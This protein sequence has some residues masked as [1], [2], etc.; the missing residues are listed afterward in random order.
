MNYYTC[1][2]LRLEEGGENSETVAAVIEK[3]REIDIIDYAL[4]EDLSTSAPATWYDYDEDM[5]EVSRAFPRVHFVLSGD[6]DDNE[7]IWE[8]HFW[9][10]KSAKYKAEIR[11]P[12]LNMADLS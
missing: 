8:H 3:L 9:N 1:Y 12:P 7:D 10:G 6:G 5:L 4:S 2:S 11:I